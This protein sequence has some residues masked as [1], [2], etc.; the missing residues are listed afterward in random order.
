MNKHN[1]VFFTCFFWCVV[2]FLGDTVDEEFEG[3]NPISLS[4]NK[5]C[6]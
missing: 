4:N 1:L 5:N 6:K 2:L 3:L